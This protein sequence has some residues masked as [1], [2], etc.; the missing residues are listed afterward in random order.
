MGYRRDLD[1]LRGIAIALVVA[2][3]VYVGRVSGGVDVFLLLSGYFFLGSQLRAAD[4]PTRSVNPWWP[5]WRT[6]RRL[7]P[8][9]LTVLA[10][11]TLAALAAL[12]Q[13]RTLALAR[14]VGASALYFQNV[15]LARQAADYAAAGASVSPLQ[16]L[17]SMSVQ[18]QFYLAVILATCLLAATLR[19]THAPGRPSALLAAPL[20]AVTLASFAHAVRLHGS[21]QALN[22][23]STASRAW[24][25]TAGGLLAIAGARILLPARVARLA[26]PAGLAMVVSTAALFDGAAVFPGPA[27]LWPL[28]GAALV[29]A[30]GGAPGATTRLL[31]SAPMTW[32]GD[33]AYALY[34]WHWPLLILLLRAT[35]AE[36]PSAA[37]GTAVIAVSLVLAHLTHRLL[38]RPLMQHAARP[39]V[40]EARV[41]AAWAGLAAGGAP[42]ARA[43]AGAALAVVLAGL[44]ALTPVQQHRIAAAAGG[45]LDPALYPGALA[46]DQGRP[47]P[48]GVRPEPNPEIIRSLFPEP[49]KR[50]C[51]TLSGEGPETL[52]LEREDGRPCL[53][54]DPAGEREILLLGGSH[55]EQWFS[56]LDIVAARHGWRLRPLLRQGCPPVLGDIDEVGGACP[57]WTR[58]AMAHIADNP[59]DL[60][61]VTSTRPDRAGDGDFVPGPYVNFW[62]ELERLGVPF[63]ALRDTPW[64]TDDRG[65]R[66]SPTECLL[67]GGDAAS[68]GI[69]RSRVLD[70]ANPADA[71]LAGIAGAHSLDL[72]DLLC[73]PR[74]CPPVIGNIYAYRDD[75]HI[76]DELA[77]TMAARL[78]R[79]L[80]PIL[81]GIEAAG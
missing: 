23:Y 34:L 2:C 31:A 70:E 46:M 56:P 60:V 17:W 35:G 71:V 47:V 49:A 64:F 6:A 79:E 41:R 55:S 37:A 13:L 76:T 1:G 73:G 59:P 58:L 45:E 8:A 40:G 24:E 18:G 69:A 20:A 67:A 66:Y 10:A 57:E 75:N 22:Y 48:A 61:V 68:C 29:I 80:T 16:H 65:E 36:E 30:A 74:F 44:V 50:G 54:G 27:A 53:W 38:E 52:A 43:A 14:Q 77:R 4:D 3:H 81:E 51:I 5:L 9:L 39:R 26:A 28:G 19:A 78:D 42:R 12:P 11:V 15:E 21:D 33:I 7:L 25:L 63:A 32:L 62:R 72:T